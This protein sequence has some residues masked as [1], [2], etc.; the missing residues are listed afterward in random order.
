MKIKNVKSRSMTPTF[1]GGG[2]LSRLDV[3]TMFDLAK[4]DDTIIQGMGKTINL[5]GSMSAAQK[6]QIKNLFGAIDTALPAIIKADFS[7]Q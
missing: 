3:D 4:D 6:T 7:A 5:F 1:N 2:E